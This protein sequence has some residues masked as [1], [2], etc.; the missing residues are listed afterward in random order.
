MAV[1]ARA[2]HIHVSSTVNGTDTVRVVY[3]KY[4]ILIPEIRKNL[5][6]L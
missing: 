2:H 5:F 6:N 3:H 1:I 4:M